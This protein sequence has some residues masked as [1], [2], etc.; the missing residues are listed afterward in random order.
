MQNAK[1]KPDFGCIGVISML[2]N[3][4][5]IHDMSIDRDN[6]DAEKLC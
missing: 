1:I 6:N 3:V 5:L 2:E 4:I